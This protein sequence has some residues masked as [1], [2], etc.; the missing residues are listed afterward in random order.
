[1]KTITNDATVMVVD[2]VVSCD[3]DGEAAIL[4]MNDGVYYGLHPIG[5]RI[6]NL[7]QKHSTINHIVQVLLDE[8]DVEPDRCR[9]DIYE[10]LEQLL[11]NELVEIK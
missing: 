4:N 9:K 8:F 7:I 10:L 5:A 3:L 2:N 11:N 1:M 6:W